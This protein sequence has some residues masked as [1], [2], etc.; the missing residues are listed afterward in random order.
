MQILF[1][2]YLL[3]KYKPDYH[4]IKKEDWAEN[5]YKG[6]DEEQNKVI[7]TLN[8]QVADIVQTTI[9][10]NKFPVAIG[11][12]CHKTFGVMKG[13]N[14][15]E[16]SPALLW[17]DAHGDFNTFETSPS[18]FVGGM[19][20]AI[21]TGRESPELLQ[22]LDLIP[23]SEERV[24]IFDGR[25]LDEAEGIQL[26]KSKVRQPENLEE[27]LKECNKEKE[28]YIHLDAD[29]I[30]PLDAP[31]MLYQAKGGPRLSELKKFFETI[32][33]KVVAISVTMWEP[34]LDKDKQTEKAVLGLLKYLSEQI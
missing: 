34:S 10:Q 4:S 1:T 25:N 19:S 33:E 14:N 30:N 2:P 26:K 22:N 12:D 27:L 29:I 15:C 13:L 7:S 11:G 5:L 23:L 8:K 17:L 31:A 3:E 20:L 9:S 16:I 6:S 24:I 18:G 21:L 32:K 28:I